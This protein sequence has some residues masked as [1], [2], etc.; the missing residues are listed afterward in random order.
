VLELGNVSPVRDYISTRDT[1]VA[2][3]KLAQNEH[4]G[5]EVY[6]IATGKGASVKDLI[7]CLSRILKQEIQIKVDPGRFRQADKQVQLA[8]ISKLKEKLKWEPEFSLEEV[9]LE[10][11]EFE[12]MIPANDSKM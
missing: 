6:N 5:T 9:L 2:L 4:T 12:K 11:L 10:L 7:E 8:D 1:A 3:M